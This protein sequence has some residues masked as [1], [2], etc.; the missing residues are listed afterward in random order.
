MINE[1]H[2]QDNNFIQTMKVVLLI[3]DIYDESLC[4]STLL[5]VSLE[6]ND[7]KRAAYNRPEPRTASSSVQGNFRN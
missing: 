7:S 1:Y 4:V 3:T 5:I 6:E 2:S